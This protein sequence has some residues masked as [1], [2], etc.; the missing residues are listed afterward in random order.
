MSKISNSKSIEKVNYILYNDHRASKYKIA[1]TQI[2]ERAMTLL[3]HI[4]CEPSKDDHAKSQSTAISAG[5]KNI[6]KE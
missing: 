6:T 4:I 2:K 5:S 3:G 1:A